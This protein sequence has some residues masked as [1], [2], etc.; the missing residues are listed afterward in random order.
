MLFCVV[1]IVFLI[2]GSGLQLVF[3]FLHFARQ[4]MCEIPNLLGIFLV[5]FIEKY[6]LFYGILIRKKKLK[7]P[8]FIF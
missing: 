4:I 8:T 2:S 6:K 5:S 3:R 7:N 1:K